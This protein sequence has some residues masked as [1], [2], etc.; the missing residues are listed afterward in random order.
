[1]GSDEPPVSMFSYLISSEFNLPAKVRAKNSPDNSVWFKA[2]K[3]AK[4]TKG[5]HKNGDSYGRLLC[6]GAVY[7]WVI[8]SDH[9]TAFV[10]IVDITNTT[11]MHVAPIS[12]LVACSFVFNQR[13]L[14]SCTLHLVW[15]EGRWAKFWC[16]TMQCSIWDH[17]KCIHFT[18]IYS[19][20][21]I[22]TGWEV[23]NDIQLISRKELICLLSA[24]AIWQ[25][26]KTKKGALV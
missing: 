14:Q 18:G 11:S 15:R 10:Q 26:K 23:H 25:K 6:A 17:A 8:S 7:L 20:L 2:W 5:L 4:G 9:M 12:M 19:M 13:S 24:T 3:F 1:M 21:S 22:K 16:S